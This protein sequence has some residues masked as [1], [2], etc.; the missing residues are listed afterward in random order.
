MK[1]MPIISITLSLFAIGLSMASISLS[2]GSISMRK[3]FMI[4]RK[5]C[6]EK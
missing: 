1:W 6:S 5:Q 4:R 2:I 3:P